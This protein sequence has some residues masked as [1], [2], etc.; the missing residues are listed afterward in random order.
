MS[1][2][3]AADLLD[4]LAGGVGAAC[5]GRGGAS[6][7]RRTGARLG[8]DALER[9]LRRAVGLSFLLA[10][11]APR[12]ASAATISAELH[13]AGISLGQDARL[14]VAIVGSQNAPRPRLPPIDGLEMRGIGQTM[15]HADRGEDRSTAR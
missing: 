10:A 13:P 3:D 5:D 8:E 7:P 12:A 9:T 14:S 4:S 2:H 11:L 15:R 6:L 1:P